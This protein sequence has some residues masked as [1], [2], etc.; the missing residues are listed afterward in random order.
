MEPVA[1]VTVE[2]E[3]STITVTAA[4]ETEAYKQLRSKLEHIPGGTPIKDVQVHMIT[5]EVE[6][7]EGV[8]ASETVG[9]LRLV[10][11]WRLG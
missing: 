3:D 5:D 1:V 2:F 7:W 11:D 8:G 6:T 9:W 4:T 10:L